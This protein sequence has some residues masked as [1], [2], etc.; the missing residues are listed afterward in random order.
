MTKILRILLI[1][2]TL[3][4]LASCGLIEPLFKDDLQS[5][6][7]DS[8]T[9]IRNSNVGVNVDLY[10]QV[11]GRFERVA[12]TS[13]GS[14]VVFYADATYYYAI[15]NHHVIDDKDFARAEYSVVPS[16]QGNPIPAVIIAQD[17]SKDLAIIRFTKNNIDIPLMDIT[18]RLNIPLNS[19]EMVLAVGNPNAVN[20]IV[21]YGEVLNLVTIS[22]VD[23]PVI[24]HSALI[25]P[26]NSGGALTDIHGA[27]IGINTWGS[28]DTDE[29]N[30]AVPLDQ[31]VAF[32]ND[33]G[34]T[35]EVK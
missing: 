18:S 22:Q 14:G 10:Q 12:G 30:M 8:R 20:S 11:S 7:M 6:L 5:Q 29:R 9:T 2:M 19:G 27:L 4:I 13:R 26:G 3:T 1:V 23:F 24:L 33:N 17:I 34:F 35:I 32:L 25:F 31:I 16:Q 28:E 15:T 21:T